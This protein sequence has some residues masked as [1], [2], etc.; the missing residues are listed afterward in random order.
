MKTLSIAVFTMAM[1]TG[2]MVNGKSMFGLAPQ[3]PGA[4]MSTGDAVATPAPAQHREKVERFVVRLEQVAGTSAHWEAFEHKRCTIEYN[5]LLEL[6][7]SPAT[8]VTVKGRTGTIQAFE[9]EYCTNPVAS[10]AQQEDRDAAARRAA[11]QAE[12][13]RRD[14][15]TP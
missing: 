5:E 3:S 14:G 7:V 6:G 11:R 13:A 12:Q 1:A 15:T 10:R 4:A 8:T 9:L 2:C